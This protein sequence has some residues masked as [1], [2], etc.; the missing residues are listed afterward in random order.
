MSG[1]LSD[2]QRQPQKLDPKHII[3]SNM[4]RTIIEVLKRTFQRD[5]DLSRKQRQVKSQLENNTLPIT[6]FMSE[7][8][9][10][11]ELLIRGASLPDHWDAAEK[12]SS[13]RTLRQYQD[14]PVDADEFLE[15]NDGYKYVSTRTAGSLKTMGRTMMEQTSIGEQDILGGWQGRHAK[16]GRRVQFYWYSTR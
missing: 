5:E 12:A 8:Q 16:H 13:L 14:R 4:Q 2:K 1:K 11:A 6:G 9:L 3:P 10:E 7:P 15:T